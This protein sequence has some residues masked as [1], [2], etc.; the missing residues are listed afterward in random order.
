M[1][2]FPLLPGALL[3]AS[4]LW[5]NLPAQAAPPALTDVQDIAPALLAQIG[6]DKPACNAP[7]AAF[8]AT[9]NILAIEVNCEAAGRG[10]RVWLLGRGERVVAATPELGTG[11]PNAEA[12]FSSGTDLLWV[13]D[14]LYVFTTEQGKKK[15][16]DIDPAWEPRHYA[17]TLATGPRS[18]KAVA[19]DIQAAYDART[20]GFPGK[21]PDELI[22]DPD[23][24]VDSARLL[25]KP[26]TRGRAAGTQLVWLSGLPD[27]RYALRVK[28]LTGSSAATELTR[29]GPELGSLRAD[30][31][32]LVYPSPQGL[33]LH[34]LDQR[35]TQ[36]LQGT[37]AGDEPLAWR[38]TPQAHRLAWLSMHACAK[39]RGAAGRHLCV[40]TVTGVDTPREP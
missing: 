36:T 37:D 20:G 13:A 23:L 16:A 39:T 3:A 22:D 8:D 10:R 5:L 1:K 31:W 7:Q 19:P 9:G 27:D 24:I 15:Q 12:V 35:N 40:A 33:V 2:R 18:I 26:T 21:T 17:A 32:S 14:T 30:N 11:D 34:R 25:G 29:G 6:L 28:A 38:Q 4:L